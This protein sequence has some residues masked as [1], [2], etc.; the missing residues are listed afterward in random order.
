M[1]VFCARTELALLHQS[2]FIVC[3]GTFEMAPDCAYQLYTLHGFLHGEALPLAWALLPNKCT[4][5]YVELFSSLNDAFV[6][7]FGDSGNHTFLVDY[8]QA[9]IKALRQVFPQSRIRGCSFHFRQ[10]VYRSVQHEGLKAQYEDETSPV[11]RWIRQLLAMS[12]LPEFAVSLAWSWLSSP[13]SV[14]PL[15]DVKT[16][17][18]AEY[19]ESTW[20]QGDFPPT[21]WTHFDNL[22]PRTTNVAEGFHNGMHSRFGMAHPSLR[23]FLDWLQKFQFEIQSRGL[24]LLAGRPPKQRPDVYVQLDHN[25]WSA[26]LQYGL[27]YGQIFCSYPYNSSLQRFHIATDHYLCRVSYLSGCQ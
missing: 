9:A 1:Q 6:K 22:G 3:D 23:M 4:A 8:E 15:T 11:R 24:Q 2:E 20:I 18:L 12:A 21:L 13:P 27:Q 25:L 26:K 5:T 19:F 14:D 10:A 7:E 17:R 16:R